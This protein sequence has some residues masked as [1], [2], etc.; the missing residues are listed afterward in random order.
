MIYGT[1]GFYIQKFN[2]NFGLQKSHP[3]PTSLSEKEDF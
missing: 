2:Y 1:L 3:H